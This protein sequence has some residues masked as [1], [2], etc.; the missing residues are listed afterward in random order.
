MLGAAVVLTLLASVCLADDRDPCSAESSVS[1]VQFTLALNG[2]QSV[3]H[4]GEIIPLRLAFSTVSS[5]YFVNIFQH[6]RY[7]RFGV[8]LFCV[9]PEAPDPLR[10][11]LQGGS[12]ESGEISE[13]RLAA[14]P[15]T[16]EEYLNEWRRQSFPIEG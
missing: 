14:A 6:E 4:E 15:F 11:Y 13:L 8:D 9:E 7:G 12:L 5:R 10:N 1:D 16:T 3:F 2:G